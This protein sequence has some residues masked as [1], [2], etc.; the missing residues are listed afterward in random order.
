MT[1]LVVACVFIAVSLFGFVQGSDLI[2]GSI[3]SG[4]RLLYSQIS[5]APGIPGGLAYLAVNYTGDYSIT[6]LRAFDR[7]INRSG[8]VVLTGGGF[9][10]RFVNLALQTRVVGDPVEYLV[11]IYG[12]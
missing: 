4:D 1:K 12:R 6:A 3:G 7:S 10:Q 2:M 8:S 9:L 11:E 5:T